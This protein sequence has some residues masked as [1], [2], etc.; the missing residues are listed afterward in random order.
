[1]KLMPTTDAHDPQWILIDV[2]DAVIFVEVT[3]CGARAIA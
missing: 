3:R 2:R 1:M